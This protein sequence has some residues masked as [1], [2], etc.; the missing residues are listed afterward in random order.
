MTRIQTVI[1][2][3]AT[4]T[5]SRVWLRARASPTRWWPPSPQPPRF[6]SSCT[7]WPATK[8][9]ARTWCPAAWWRSRRSSGPALSLSTSPSWPGPLTP[10]STLSSRGWSIYYKQISRHTV[11]WWPVVIVTHWFNEHCTGR[12]NPWE[13][14]D[15]AGI[16]AYGVTL[17]YVCSDAGDQSQAWDQAQSSHLSAHHEGADPRAGTAPGLHSS[18]EAGELSWAQASE[19]SALIPQLKNKKL[20]VQPGSDLIS[21]PPEDY[22]HKPWTT[23]NIW[24]L[25]KMWGGDNHALIQAQLICGLREERNLRTHSK[26]AQQASLWSCSAYCL[27]KISNTKATISRQKI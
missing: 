24:G 19:P 18:R 21:Q 2:A 17:C 20:F 14:W 23:F 27:N 6:S 5:A 13:G 22:K 9:G 3:A 7:T 8:P 26:Q 16:S 12:L 11:T 25:H 15:T 4:P 1:T 10:A